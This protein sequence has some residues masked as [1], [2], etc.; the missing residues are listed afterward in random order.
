MGCYFN[1]LVLF[2][3]SLVGKV[4][5][6]IIGVHNVHL[7]ICWFAF[8]TWFCSHEHLI[9]K[10]FSQKFVI[11]CGISIYV[12]ISYFVPWEYGN[13]NLMGTIATLGGILALWSMANILFPLDYWAIEHTTLFPLIFSLMAFIISWGLTWLLLKT[14][15]GKFLI[16]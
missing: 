10:G 5:P 12:I 3:I 14:R 2:A 1:P 6:M 16:G 4:V 9:T 7:W 11:V 8:G 15:F 13:N